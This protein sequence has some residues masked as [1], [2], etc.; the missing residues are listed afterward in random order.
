MR[1]HGL[2]IIGALALSAG[3]AGCGRSG[4]GAAGSDTLSAQ[5]PRI[6]PLLAD[7]PAGY[8]TANL[9]N[10]RDLFAQCRACHTVV[11]DGPN[12]TG[13]NLYGVFGRVAGSHPGFS[14]SAGLKASGIIWDSA[15]LDRWLTEPRA[16]ISGTK[17]A[18]MGV[19][20]P[21]DRRDVIAYLKVASSG[22]PM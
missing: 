13:P 19:K 14:Y 9:S 3:L 11:K 16:M 6:K 20:D 17:M 2:M 4:G 1:V 22:G 8:Q 15:S 5:D 12:M 18:Y 21:S 7:L 10:G